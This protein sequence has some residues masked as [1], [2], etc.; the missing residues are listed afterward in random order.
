M[1]IP[2]G[3]VVK[4]PACQ[5]KRRG[6]D[7]WVGKIPGGRN[8]N[9]LQYSHLGNPMDTG[10]WWHTGVAKSQTRLNSKATIT[11]R[12]QRMRKGPACTHRLRHREYT[13]YKL[14]IDVDLGIRRG[15]IQERNADPG[16]T[17]SGILIQFLLELLAISG[18]VLPLRGDAVTFFLIVFPRV[19]LDVSL[20]WTFKNWQL[21]SILCW[22][23]KL[24]F[25]WRASWVD[26]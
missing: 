18:S 26:K 5:C 12:P 15:S 8:G 10:A 21:L 23:I 6:F 24:L 1:G 4:E 9:S 16:P 11:T 13:E 14:W 17:V 19:Y 7:P 22:W 20:L 3:S 2:G 25:S